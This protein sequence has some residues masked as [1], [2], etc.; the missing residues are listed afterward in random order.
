MITAIAISLAIS[1]IISLLQVPEYAKKQ[2]DGFAAFGA[3]IALW[4]VFAAAWLFFKMT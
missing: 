4:Y 1:G 2:G 3:V